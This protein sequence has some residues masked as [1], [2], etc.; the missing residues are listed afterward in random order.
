MPANP[1]IRI[2]RRAAA[3]CIRKTITG[4]RMLTASRVKEAFL[5]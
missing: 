1:V 2:R 5:L 4:Y 3:G